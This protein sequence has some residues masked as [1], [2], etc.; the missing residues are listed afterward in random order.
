MSWAHL[1]SQPTKAVS[2][3]NGLILQLYYFEE[4]ISDSS[5]LEALKQG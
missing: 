1:I 3:L 5:P 2:F 4:G